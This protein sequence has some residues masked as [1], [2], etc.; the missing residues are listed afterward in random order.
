[1]SAS[2]PME[3]L[4]TRILDGSAPAAAKSAAARGILPIPRTELVKVLV[5]LLNDSS[6]EIRQAAATSLAEIPVAAIETVLTDEDVSPE[7]LIHFSRVAVKDDVTIYA[8]KIAFNMAASGEAIE[9]LAAAGNDEM[10]SL[11]LTNMER[12]TSSPNLLDLLLGNTAVRADQKSLIQEIKERLDRLASRETA[13]TP[14]DAEGTEDTGA[15]EQPDEDELTI[16]DVARILEVDVG[17]LLTA[18]EIAGGNEFEEEGVPEEI[19]GVY[20]KII[21]LNTSQKAIMAIKGGREERSILIRDTNRL[22]ALA[23]LKNP[24]L[25]EGEIESIAGMRNVHEAVLRY[26]GSYREWTKNYNI[27]VSLVRNPRT[28]PGVSTNFINRLNN[29]DLKSLSKDKNVPELIR[30]MSKRTLD[31]REQKSKVPFKKH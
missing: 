15:E 12:L 22:V 6:E 23:V 24:R 18:S 27:T 3:E 25:P 19:R 9:I 30:R 5:F 2:N 28:P 26:I 10:I 16:E 14:E 20:Q 8:E 13:P 1:M 11:V 21:T 29:R 17:E 4:V 31:Q 7:V